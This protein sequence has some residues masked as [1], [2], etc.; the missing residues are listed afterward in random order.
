MSRTISRF[1]SSVVRRASS[2]WRGCDLATSVT[3]DA[4]LSRRARDQRVVRRAY[5]GPPGRAE[6]REPGVAQVELVARAGEELGVLGVGARP[7]ALDEAD[8]ELVEL[9]GD[10]QLVGDGEVQPLLL[11]AVAQGRVVDVELALQ[12]DLGVHRAVLVARAVSCQGNK[13]TP[14]RDE[15][16][17]RREC[18]DALGDDDGAAHETIVTRTGAARSVDLTIRP[19]GP[20][21]NGQQIV[22]NEMSEIPMNGSPST[23]PSCAYVKLT[24]VSLPGHAQV[25]VGVLLLEPSTGL[26]VVLPR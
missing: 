26:L 15:R 1:S 8:A 18:A 10:G 20:G 4:P 23:L 25:D 5:A 6:R 17:A 16:S 19:T 14:R 9:P 12:V 7:A 3:T 11:R 2:T 21:G 24:E 22:W 13:K